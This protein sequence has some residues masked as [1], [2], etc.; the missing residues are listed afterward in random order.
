M[1]KIFALCFVAIST[2][3]MAQVDRSIMPA[4]T[5][6]KKINIKD[7]EVFTTANGIT[8]ILSENHKLPR[9]SFDL[10]MG[11]DPRLE[12][13][14]AGLSA[15]AGSLIMSGTTNRTKDQLD[16]EIDFIGASLG[17]DQSSISLSCLTKHMDKG[18]NLMSDVLFHANFPQSEFDRIKKQNVSSLISTKSD[19]ESMVQNATVK[20]NFPNHPFSDVMTEETLNNITREDI[21]SFY[22]ANF[23]PNGSY[24]VVVGDITRK[25]TEEMVNKYFA[26]WTGGPAYKNELNDGDFSKGNRV[27]FVK[28]PGAVQSVVY[29]TFPIKMKT[30]DKNQLPLTVLNGILGGGGFGTR[31]MQ[32]LREDKAYTYGCYSSLNITEDGSWM[33]AGGNFQNAV[34]D[35]AIEQILLEF[36]KI[37]NEYVKDEELNLTKTNM[38]GGFARSLERPQT[39]ARFALNIIKNNLAKD[40]YQTYLQRLESVSKEDILQMAQQYFTSKNCNIIVVGNEE[41]FDKLKR[42]DADG[43]IEVLDPFGNEMKETKKADITADQVIERYLCALTNT[44]KSKAAKKKLKEVISLERIYELSGDQIPFAIKMTEVFV[45]PTTEGQKLEGQGMLFQ[46]SFY[47]GKS[48]FTF[49][50]QTGKTELTA[51]E[52]TSKAKSNGLVPEVNYK[53][54]KVSYELVGIESMNGNDYYVLKVVDGKNESYDYFHKNTFMKEK[55]VS[56]LQREGQ[57]MESTV[58]F[59]DYKEVNGVKFAHSIVQSVGP[60]V[61]TGTVTSIKVNEEIDLSTFELIKDLN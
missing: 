1:K 6:A 14:K 7:S 53:S 61:L 24:L 26:S 29:V 41:V 3:T 32:N 17:A 39:I 35:S 48:G 56:V 13:S 54:K 60:M 28:K 23:T 58:T 19:A 59:G 37:T 36:Q 12:G 2:W 30:G 33:S 44:T 52:L 42:F 50:P 47:N 51:D 9:V 15:M 25:Q 49:N 38:A 16:Q 46:K 31:L 5:Q 45:S 27:V 11:S 4:P 20:I 57:T 18:L 40:Y 55:T 8:V 10:S 22:Q 43:K 21:I 34:T